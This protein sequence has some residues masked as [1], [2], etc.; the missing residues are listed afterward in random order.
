[1]R[2]VY[3]AIHFSIFVYENIKSGSRSANISMI[4]HDKHLKKM[5][6]AIL[7]KIKVNLQR[8]GFER[9]KIA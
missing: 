7:K 8:T 6:T 3:I 9:R 5:L 2:Y 1:M 4:L